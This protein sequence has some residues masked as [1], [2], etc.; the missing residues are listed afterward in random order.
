MQSQPQPQP[1]PQLQPQPQH[2]K[3][4]PSPAYALCNVHLRAT[5]EGGGCRSAFGPGTAAPPGQGTPIENGAAGTTGTGGGQGGRCPG[6]SMLR[7]AANQRATLQLWEADARAEVRPGEGQGRDR[8]LREAAR[9]IRQREM[10]IQET[11]CRVAL[12]QVY[13]E[14][15]EAIGRWAVSAMQW[16]RNRINTPTAPAELGP[17]GAGR[18]SGPRRRQPNCG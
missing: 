15:G 2:L 16:E 7:C 18:S 9:A 17:A 11:R 5:T 10:D 12:P 1:Q 6:L 3:G 4:W 8:V 13:W 14:R